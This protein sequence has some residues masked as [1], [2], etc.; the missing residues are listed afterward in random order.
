MTTLLR[1]YC[2]RPSTHVVTGGGFVTQRC[3]EHAEEM[4]GHGWG[5]RRV[6]AVSTL[7]PEPDSDAGTDVG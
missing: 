7:A 1:C 3:P 4:R 6:R 2:G 5:I